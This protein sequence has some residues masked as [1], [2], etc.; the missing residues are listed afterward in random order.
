M[1]TTNPIRIPERTCVGCYSQKE[2]SALIHVVKHDGIIKPDFDGKAPGR[3]A[4][5][6]KCAD[7]I[8]LAQKKKGL[9]RSLKCSVTE[10]VYSDLLTYIEG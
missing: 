5:V 9:E 6:C 8:R 1:K 4:Y 2:K 10:N 7:C 3:G